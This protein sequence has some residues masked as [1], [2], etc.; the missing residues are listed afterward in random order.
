M[1]F[2]ALPF[3]LPV[4][5][6]KGPWQTSGYYIAITSFVYWCSASV[7][8]WSYWYTY[9]NIMYH[10]RQTQEYSLMLEHRRT[11]P[12]LWLQYHVSC[13]C[14]WCYAGVALAAKTCIMTKFFAKLL[15]ILW[16]LWG[17]KFICYRV[18]DKSYRPW[19]YNRFCYLILRIKTS[20]TEPY[21]Q[22]YC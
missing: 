5:F 9:R 17:K 4:S 2:V 11:L 3:S 20:A 6:F 13:A 16:K 14:R 15:T 19:I 21:N 1:V 12:L 7:K 8:R 18:T 22:E 10:N